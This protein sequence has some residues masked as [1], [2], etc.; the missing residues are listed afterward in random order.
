MFDSQDY[1]TISGENVVI[2]NRAGPVWYRLL[3][4]RPGVPLN[5]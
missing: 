3:V 5:R 2:T 1:L 4:E